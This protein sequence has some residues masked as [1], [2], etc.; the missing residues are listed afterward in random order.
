[1]RFYTLVVANFDIF[2]PKLPS[3]AV[4]MTAI[5]LVILI[6]AM[7]GQKSPVSDMPDISD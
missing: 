2:K 5:F 1:M 7:N 6:A 3:V 4:P